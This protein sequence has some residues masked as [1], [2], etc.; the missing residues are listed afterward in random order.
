MNRKFLVIL[1]CL[2]VATVTLIALQSRSTDSLHYKTKEIEE[3]PLVIIV[4]SYNNSEWVEKNIQS[5][6]SQKYSNYRVIYIDDCSDDN[7]YELVKTYV[8]QHNMNDRITIIKNKSRKFALANHFTAGHMCKDHEIMVHLDGDDWFKDDH[9]LQKV[10]HVYSDP[11]VWITY[12]QYEVYPGGRIGLCEDFPKIV[13]QKNIYREYQWVSSHLRTFYAW[14][15]KKIKLKDCI[16]KGHWI[17]VCCDRVMMFALLEMAREH[18]KFIP[19]VLYVYNC[20]TS[21]N[22]FKKHLVSQWHFNHIISAQSK[23]PKINKSP[24]QNP[25][26]KTDKKT[27]MIIFSENNPML[28]QALLESAQMNIRNINFNV[29][30]LAENK[31]FNQGYQKLKNK[32]KNAKFYSYNKGTES[33]LSS[34][35]D[36]ILTQNNYVLFA[37]DGIIIK[38]PINID[39][40]LQAIEKTHAYG[41]YFTLGKNITEYKNLRRPQ[42]LPPFVEVEETISAWPFEC[43]EYN[44]SKPQSFSLALYNAQT[45]KRALSHIVY[46][47]PESLETLWAQRLFDPKHVGL[48]YN[49][50]PAVIFNETMSPETSLTLF[51]QGLK[52]DCSTIAHIENKTIYIN[53]EM[54]L[55]S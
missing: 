14:L 23:Y 31:Q 26:N 4:L 48:I 16:H 11:N 25:T 32:F 10:N 30:Y 46:D 28:A 36:K 39:R 33:N 27:A 41:F 1:T 20:A 42:K 53:K 9:V 44:W 12:G 51:E 24:I 54:P 21:G 2:C 5:I 3:K 52:L 6:F 55:I 22:L 17:P 34:I 45:V 38:E 43:G 35:I 7:T 13:H 8:N 15:F 37:H 29:V 50:S 18:S 47:S 49:Q 40:S 19:D